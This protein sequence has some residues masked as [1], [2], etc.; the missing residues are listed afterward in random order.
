MSGTIWAGLQHSWICGSAKVYGNLFCIVTIWQKGKNLS[1]LEIWQ[2]VSF[3]CTI[4]SFLCLSQRVSFEPSLK[5]KVKEERGVRR[6]LN[7]EN[8]SVGNKKQNQRY[9]QEIL[10]PYMKFICNLESSI[11]K[12]N[13]S[14]QI[15]T[16]I[17][18]EDFWCET[19]MSPI[20]ICKIKEYI[21]N[22]YGI[23]YIRHSVNRL[24][25]IHLQ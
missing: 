23:I 11:A 9:L 2:K 8:L 5:T 16:L 1:I 3:P 24:F 22:Y 14:W 17:M 12:I 25:R 19:F 21:M 4:W 20:F 18:L 13:R 7:W 15:Q 10:L 6:N